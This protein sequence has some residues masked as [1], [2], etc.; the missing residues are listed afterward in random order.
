MCHLLSSGVLSLQDGQYWVPR[1]RLLFCAEDP[2]VFAQ[3]VLFAQN[4]RQETEASLLYHLSIDC[5][6]VWSGSPTLDPRRM[7]HIKTYACSTSGLQ[8]E[9]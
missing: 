3:R 2:R 5:M 9:L 1:I 6:P 8:L 4:L 7:E